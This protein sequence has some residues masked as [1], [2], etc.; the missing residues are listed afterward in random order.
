MRRLTCLIE[1]LERKSRALKDATAQ[2]LPWEALT[3][4]AAAARLSGRNV[5]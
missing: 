1:S 4:V 5:W 3:S 2:A